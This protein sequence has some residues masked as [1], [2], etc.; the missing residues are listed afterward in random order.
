MICEDDVDGC[1][2]VEGMYVE[3]LGTE[4]VAVGVDEFAVLDD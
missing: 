3:C 1:L 2:E 4:V